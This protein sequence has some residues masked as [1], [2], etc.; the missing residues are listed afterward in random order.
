MTRLRIKDAIARAA[1]AGSG[2]TRHAELLILCAR[3][4]FNP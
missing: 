4:D 2:R 3:I 1:A